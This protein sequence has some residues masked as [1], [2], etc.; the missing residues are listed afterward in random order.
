MKYFRVNCEHRSLKH[1]PVQKVY[2][3]RRRIINANL[4]QFCEQ[5]NSSFPMWPDRYT[6]CTTHPMML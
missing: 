3:Y 4:Y 2:T 1:T 5:K 6:M